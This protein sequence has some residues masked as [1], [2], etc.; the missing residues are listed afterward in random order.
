MDC[1]E[2][3][4]DEVCGIT[5]HLKTKKGTRN[6]EI[7]FDGDI[8]EGTDTKSL[9][10]GAHGNLVS[11]PYLLGDLSRQKERAESV[12]K[13]PTKEPRRPTLSGMRDQAS[14]NSNTIVEA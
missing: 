10:L 2:G 9:A 11:Q 7:L 4:I 3:A 1:W 12:T 8:R 6:I 14:A 5:K 13:I